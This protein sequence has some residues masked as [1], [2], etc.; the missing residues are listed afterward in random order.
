MPNKWKMRCLKY[1]NPRKK[2]FKV[3][4]LFSASKALFLIKALN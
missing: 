3:T 4:K 1:C 2:T